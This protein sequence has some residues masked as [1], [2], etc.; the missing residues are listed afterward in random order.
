M[1]WLATVLSAVGQVQNWVGS[2]RTRMFQLEDTRDRRFA[3]RDDALRDLYH[4]CIGLLPE[5]RR[6]WN[7]ATQR[8]KKTDARGNIRIESTSVEQR[9]QHAADLVT[10]RDTLR[11]H[12]RDF[13]RIAL[14]L[15]AANMDPEFSAYPRELEP[16]YA[17]IE[18]V[19]DR[20][21]SKGTLTNR[22]G[23]GVDWVTPILNRAERHIK[24]RL[25]R[26]A[27]RRIT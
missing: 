3:E 21:A 23:D 16:Y 14:R 8:W 10:L 26:Q 6:V 22:D 20:A 18:R 11:R 19:L 13:Q 5:L 7:D 17:R 2:R 12:W 15:G 1:G 24:R 4:E 27:A 9:A 25:E